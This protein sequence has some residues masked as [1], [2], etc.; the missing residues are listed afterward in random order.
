MGEGA[1]LS[2]LFLG[3]MSDIIGFF[4]YLK[5]MLWLAQDL[6]S[7]WTQTRTVLVNS[8]A[9]MVQLMVLALRL[10]G[11]KQGQGTALPEPGTGDLG[12]PWTP[13]RWQTRVLVCQVP[14]NQVA[15]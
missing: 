5:V 9:G 3:L 13:G 10:C 15:H 7:N 2:W 14:I 8:A 12:T 4:S 11:D 1:H 6:F